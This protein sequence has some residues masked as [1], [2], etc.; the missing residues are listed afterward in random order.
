MSAIVGA[1]SGIA[2]NV[3]VGALATPRSVTEASSVMV[4]RRSSVPAGTRLVP[5]S[6]PPSVRPVVARSRRVPVARIT[7]TLPVGTAR[8]RA[9][10]ACSPTRTPG[11]ITG[12]LPV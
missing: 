7:S 8:A 4:K 10:R 12:G 6:G 2:V 9:S 5:W 3:Q 11:R 1:R